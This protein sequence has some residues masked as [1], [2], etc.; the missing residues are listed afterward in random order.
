MKKNKMRVSHRLKKLIHTYKHIFYPLF[1]NFAM[2]LRENINIYVYLKVYKVVLANKKKV[3]QTP[4]RN[5][6]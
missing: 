2:A 6:Q 4:N 3:N 1:H 5:E